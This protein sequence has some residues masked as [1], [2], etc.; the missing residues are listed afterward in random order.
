[1]F[2]RLLYQS[3]I[4]Q[5]R[6]KL[7]ALIAVAMGMTVATAMIAVRLDVGDKMN[8]EIRTLG[9]NIVV[10]PAADSLDVQIGGVNLKPVSDG[11]YINESD[12]P[13]MNR[14]F[15]SHNIVGYSP[16]LDATVKVAGSESPVPIIGTYFAKGIE[17]KNSTYV[18]G[19]RKTHPWWKVEG[20]WPRDEAQE[21][22]L[23]ARLA[24]K[25]HWSKPGHVYL[26]DRETKVSGILSTGDAEEDAV[27]APLAMVQQLIGKPGAVRRVFVSA[28]T[29]PEDAFARRD[30]KTMS[31]EMLERWSC[32]PYANSIAFQISEAIPNVKA[33]QIRRIAQNEGVVLSKISGLMSLVA[34]AAVLASVLA[35]SA[36]MAAAILERRREI[37]LLKSLGAA[38]GS[39]AALFVS[40]SALLGT[41]GGLIGVGAGYWLAQKVSTSVFNARIQWE[42]ALIPVILL[43]GVFVTFAGSSASIRRALKV[44]PAT[45]LRGDI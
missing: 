11:A 42:P 12:L 23:G 7:L 36:A 16:M 22:L 14:I 27:V 34:L 15:W 29:K 9:A 17:L 8:S 38:N 37:G 41:V 25:L 18:T 10:T 45:V 26:N 5:K 6:R 31:P 32:T 1:M 2:L 21:V 19:V 44:E 30:P 39:V 4:R 40:E 33:E 13:K 20:E 28:L 3:L 35:V 43:L 24:K